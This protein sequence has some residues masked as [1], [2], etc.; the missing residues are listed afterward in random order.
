MHLCVY[1]FDYLPAIASDV[2]G[3]T[4]RVSLRKCII[5]GSLTRSSPAAAL[6]INEGDAHI[7][8]NAG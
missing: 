8:R 3:R 5:L 6:G 7:I 4:H 2:H 1:T